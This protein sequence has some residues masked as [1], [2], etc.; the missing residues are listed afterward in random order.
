M[1]LSAQGTNISPR[2]EGPRAD[3]GNENVLLSVNQITALLSG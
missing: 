1:P 2:A 3:I